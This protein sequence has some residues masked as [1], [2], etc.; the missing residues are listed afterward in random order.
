M[1][2]LIVD[3]TFQTMIQVRVS[4]GV[5]CIQL[6]KSRQFIFG[7]HLAYDLNLIMDVIDF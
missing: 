7:K 1:F 2:V 4:E 3:S 5:D 6:L